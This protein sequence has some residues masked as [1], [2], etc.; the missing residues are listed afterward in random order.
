[1]EDENFVLIDN[2]NDE[3]ITQITEDLMTSED[4]YKKIDEIINKYSQIQTKNEADF[5]NKVNSDEKE[6]M[7]RIF[8][9]IYKEFEKKGDLIIKN[10]NEDN[11]FTNYKYNE[12]LKTYEEIYEFNKKIQNSF[13]SKLDSLNEFINDRNIINYPIETF[14]LNNENLFSDTDFLMNFN[15]I[16]EK[17]LIPK[18]ENEN[19]CSY[20]L[21][22]Y[23]FK[24]LLI[25]DTAKLSLNKYCLKNNNSKLLSLKINNFQEKNFYELFDL[26]FQINEEKKLNTSGF[27]NSFDEKK[28]K[29]SFSVLSDEK[30]KKNNNNN[31]FDSSHLEISE[32][33]N[34]KDSSTSTSIREDDKDKFEQK[35]KN[36]EE[37]SKNQ[38]LNE[39]I[40]LPNLKEIFVSNGK[41]NDFNFFNIIPNIEII[42]FY[43]CPFYNFCIP[44]NNSITH[45]K[46]LIL[47][48]LEIINEIFEKILTQIFL[49]NC[50]LNSLEILSFKNNKI[51][52]VDFPSILEKDE[53]KNKYSKEEKEKLF[54]FFL[55]ELNLENNLI[56]KF[57][58]DNLKFMPSVKL[59]N[60]SGNNFIYSV[61]YEDLKEKHNLILFFSNNLFLTRQPIKN[62]YIKDLS[63][64]IKES[65][66]VFKSL[67]LDYLFGKQIE[68]ASLFQKLDLSNIQFNLT[69]LNLSYCNLTNEMTIEFFKDRF[70]FPNLK[71]LNLSG[72]YLTDEFFNLYIGKNNNMINKNILTLDKILKNLKILKVSN[73]EKIEFKEEN[74]NNLLDF[75]LKTKLKKL[76][77]FHTKYEIT[78]VENL[79]KMGKNLKIQKQKEQ[80]KNFNVSCVQIS[81]NFE[82]FL[83][84]LNVIDTIMY[85]KYIPPIKGSN[86]KKY[87]D[88][89]SKNFE[90]L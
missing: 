84:F 88:K 9:N 63:Q 50:I 42:K 85:V 82:R 25:N 79:R 6:K 8:D 76:Y 60:L 71:S 4:Y 87:M 86:Y 77:L 48:E 40:I 45:L 41:I 56:Y 1:M 12:I 64:R 35:G 31:S 72:N 46:I 11:E 65:E 49:N 15:E 53:I 29:N 10:Y 90:I 18:I 14:F 51:S 80:N 38:K 2:E 19:F 44:D 59:I 75:L 52:V 81:Q 13:I 37:K 22:N 17:D 78:T 47:E 3:E 89:I 26:D 67:N 39:W 36:I 68:N 70:F 30:G 54:F 28:K 73:N 20:I 33:K 74:L 34:K 24:S 27:L 58:S 43:N 55:E 21:N 61:D 16:D 57:S 23:D 66:Y 32:M 5:K 83:K 69:N 62:E 7:L